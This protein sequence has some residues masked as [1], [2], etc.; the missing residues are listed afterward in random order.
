MDPFLVVLGLCIAAL[1]ALLLNLKKKLPKYVFVFFAV[2]I[3]V[4]VSWFALGI[5]PKSVNPKKNNVQART[6]LVYMEVT[7]D[8]RIP[9]NQE[10]R[11]SLPVV[12]SG[13]RRYDGVR[14]LFKAKDASFTEQAFTE[15][16]RF[17]LLFSDG[18]LIPASGIIFSKE[19][20]LS[21]PDEFVL[22]VFFDT[23]K[24]MSSDDIRCIIENG[25]GV[26]LLAEEV[27]V[28]SLPDSSPR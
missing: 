20:A 21:F 4:G 6:P 27:S 25:L 19:G 18:T 9:A 13:A 1:L 17:S 7:K 3:I 11:I 15:K 23:P 14:F 5:N 24:D 10:I 26:E 28:T 22:K 2:A 16:V 8:V 12:V